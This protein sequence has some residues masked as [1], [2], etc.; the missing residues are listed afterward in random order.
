V[1][2]YGEDLKEDSLYGE[3]S[4]KWLIKAYNNATDKSKVFNRANFTKHAG[5]DKLQQ[6]I[7]AGLSEKEI[8]ATWQKD[9]EAFKKNRAKY[10][11]YE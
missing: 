5:T 4:L 9:L 8:K 7:E 2:C 11:I 1:L 10:L 3:V 6:Q